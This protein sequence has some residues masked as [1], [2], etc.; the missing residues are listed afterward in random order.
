MGSGFS[1]SSTPQLD[2][3]LQDVIKQ[4]CW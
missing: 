2:D 3:L 4:V 1:P